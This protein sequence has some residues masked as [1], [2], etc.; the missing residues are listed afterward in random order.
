MMMVLIDVTT[1]HCHNFERKASYAQFFDF[2]D[3]VES[4]FLWKHF[5]FILTALHNAYIID[6]RSPGKQRQFEMDV[7]SL[8]SQQKLSLLETKAKPNFHFQLV[9]NLSVDFLLC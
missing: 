7:K 5:V 9:N 2:R 6:A 4:N 1:K 3:K 8:C